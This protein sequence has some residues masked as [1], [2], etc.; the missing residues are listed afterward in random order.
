MHNRVITRGLT[1]AGVAIGSALL[2]GGLAVAMRGLVPVTSSAAAKPATASSLR[3]LNRPAHRLVKQLAAWH[4]PRI[5]KV[6]RHRAAAPRVVTVTAPPTVI[7][8]R[9]QRQAPQ[10]PRLRA[11]EAP[12]VTGRTTDR[13]RAMTSVAIKTYTVV[14]ALICGA[15]LAW[16]IDQQHVAATSAADARNWQRLARA[17]VAHD[18][19]TTHANHLLV[20]RY[21]RL[22]HRTA[23]AQM[24]LLRAVKAA[25][26]AAATAGSQATVYRTVAGRHRVRACLEQ[27]TGSGTGTGQRASDHEDELMEDHARAPPTTRR[28][29]GPPPAALGTCITRAVS[30]LPPRRLRPSWSSGTRHGGRASGLPARSRRSTAVPDEPC[31]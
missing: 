15:T 30:T 19:A 22:V 1:I 2:I 27:L 10:R 5:P 4:A 28:G 16:S 6:H 9:R 11:P 8:A 29:G 20:T 12:V 18:R 26:S 3:M 13:G 25:Q 17:T 24:K 23:T 21:N 7:P 31:G 14:I